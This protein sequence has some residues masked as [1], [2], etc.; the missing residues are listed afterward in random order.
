MDKI[1]SS[2]TM[3]E[4]KFLG[5]A[6][7]KNTTWE[8]ALWAQEMEWPIS[9]SEQYSDWGGWMIYNQIDV[10]MSKSVRRNN[11]FW[12][13]VEHNCFWQGI[14]LIEILALWLLREYPS[15]AASDVLKQTTYPNW[16]FNHTCGI[17]P[18]ASYEAGFLRF[19]LSF[20]YS[21][22]SFMLVLHFPC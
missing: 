16:N 19:I 6:M 9:K 2:W 1:I 11:W 17:T 4:M 10:Q 20:N 8:K 5:L 14:F 22:A 7:A 18:A 13:K 3:A 21:W 15:L 12:V